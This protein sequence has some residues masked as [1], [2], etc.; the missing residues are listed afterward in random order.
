MH[1]AEPK[2]FAVVKPASSIAAAHKGDGPWPLTGCGAACY[3]VPTMSEFTHLHVHSQYSL[4]DGAI[5][6]K[7]LFPKLSQL[8]MNSVALTDHGSS[9]RAFVVA[10]VDWKNAGVRR[11]RRHLALSFASGQVLRLVCFGRFGGHFP[12]AEGD[13]NGAKSCEGAGC[14]TS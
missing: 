2:T 8:G 10:T 3:A 6:L 14:E 13:L 1:L 4:L 12:N 11:N 7:D 5:R 9:Q